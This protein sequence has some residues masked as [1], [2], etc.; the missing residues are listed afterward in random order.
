MFRPGTL[1]V[2][3]AAS[4]LD[5]NFPLGAELKTLIA[6]RLEYTLNEFNKPKYSSLESQ[7]I[8]RAL[9]N[10]ACGKN[11]SPHHLAKMIS[12][13]VGLASSIDNFLEMR[14]SEPGIDICAKTAI[15]SI[16]LEYEQKADA[17]HTEA[18]RR[19]TLS[20]FDKKWHQV[21]AQVCFE[22]ASIDHLPEALQRV[23]VVSFN[24]DRTFEQF[25]RLALSRLYDLEW[26]NAVEIADK[27]TVIH[28]YGSIGRLPSAMAG[29]SLEFGETRIHD[30]LPLA[31]NIK[32]FTERVIEEATT[33]KL[34]EMIRAARTIV[35]LG[36]GY[37]KQNLDLLGKGGFPQAPRIM[38]TAVGL[39]D[40]AKSIVQSRLGQVFATTHGF[41]PNAMLEDKNCR[42]FLEEYSLALMDK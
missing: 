41:Q 28:P 4:S 11:I 2:L 24:Y 25:V 22:D 6:K 29:Y 13:G 20:S 12:R 38:G 10:G 21:F 37:H 42:Q 23:S 26:S 16:I 40:T 35:F 31:Q 7:Q 3:G 15:A 19:G 36:F 32:T 27:M 33:R 9:E 5:F 8:F 1:L 34:A 39:A 18:L 14:K 30:F 17:L